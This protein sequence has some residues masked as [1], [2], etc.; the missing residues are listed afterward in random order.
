MSSHPKLTEEGKEA[1]HALPLTCNLD[2]DMARCMCS[3]YVPWIK[4]C[5]VGH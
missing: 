2:I 5:H 1:E 4:R 3:R